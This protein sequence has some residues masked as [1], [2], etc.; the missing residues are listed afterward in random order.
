MINGRT[1]PT[2]YN[3]VGSDIV[4]SAAITSY[5]FLLVK[6]SLL[7]TL[8]IQPDR[9]RQQSMLENLQIGNTDIYCI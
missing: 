5:T 6:T 1:F 7:T 4:F 8:V 2:Q 9:Q 3:V